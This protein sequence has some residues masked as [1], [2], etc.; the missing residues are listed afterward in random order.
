MGFI[1][2]LAGFFAGRKKTYSLADLTD[3]IGT[4]SAGDFQGWCFGYCIRV[5][6]EDTDPNHNCFM[7]YKYNFE[8]I[9]LRFRKDF[10]KEYSIKSQNER[11]ILYEFTLNDGKYFLVPTD[12]DGQG[13]IERLLF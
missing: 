7:I 11:E 9:A 13:R 12:T 2:K 4:I 8:E 3:Y 5:N 6:K 10:V 1:D